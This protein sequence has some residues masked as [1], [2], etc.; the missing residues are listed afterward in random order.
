M[1]LSRFSNFC[2]STTTCMISSTTVLIENFEPYKSISLKNHFLKS[3]HQKR[4]SSKEAKD[5]TNRD[6]FWFLDSCLS[7]PTSL[8]S[9]FKSKKENF[10]LIVLFDRI[11]FRFN[12]CITTMSFPNLK[13]P[14]N[15]VERRSSNSFLSGATELISLSKFPFYKFTH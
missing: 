11:S 2:F 1:V 12:R 9:F 4:E 3:F 6:L 14:P 10:F 8:F 13:S 5:S 7:I 15:L